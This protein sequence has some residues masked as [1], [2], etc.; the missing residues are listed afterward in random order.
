MNDQP[1]VV[2][3]LGVLV[4]KSATSTK[5]IGRG[6]CYTNFARDAKRLQGIVRVNLGRSA[7]AIVVVTNSENMSAI[8]AMCKSHELIVDV[9]CDSFD[10]ELDATSA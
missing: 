2:G 7:D 10:E 1:A 4:L 9:S 3:P 8:S 6:T 5:Q